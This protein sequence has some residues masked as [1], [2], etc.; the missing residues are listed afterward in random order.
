[1]ATHLSPRPAALPPL[2]DLAVAY[3]DLQQL[4]LTTPQLDAFLAGL[5]SLAAEVIPPVSSCAIM[6]RRGGEPITVTASDALARRLDEMQYGRGVG[7]CLQA[8]HTG[9]IVTVT[10]LAD[11]QRWGDY[12]A[13]ALSYG[14]AASLS[15]P[16]TVGGSTIGAMNLYSAHAHEFTAAEVAQSGAFAAQASGALALMQRHETQLR[17]NAQLEN[18][19][20]SRAVIDQAMGVLMGTRRISATQAFDSLRAQSQH[21]NVKLHAVA[22]EIVET[23]TEHAVQAAPAFTQR[24]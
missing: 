19:L 12:P 18:A 10:D 21:R 16:L 5:A 23:F 15:L 8:L 14:V 4:L 6:L 3:H 24:S 2:P 22:V 9:E 7:P 20:A 17:V 1:M 11:E 13:H